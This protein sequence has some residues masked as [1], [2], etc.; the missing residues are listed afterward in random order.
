MSAPAIDKGYLLEALRR[1][2]EAPSPTG[3]TGAASAEIERMAGELGYKAGRRANGALVVTVP[4]PGD[5][6]AAVAA[7]FDTLGLMVRGINADGTLAFTSIGGNILPTLDGEYCR[8]HSASGRVYTGTVLSAAASLHVFPEAKT[9][10]R[11]EGNM[12]IRIDERV[13]SREEAAALGIE[14]GDFVSIEPKFCLTASGYVK[15]RHL[16]DKAGTACLLAALKLLAESGRV[17][18]RTV[19]FIFSAQEETGCG[20]SS[21]PEGV[22]TLIGVDMGCVGGELACTEHDVSL[23]VKDSSGPYDRALT[24]ELYALAQ[25]NGISC[26]KDV[27]PNYASDVSAARMGGN[28]IAG[29]L[30]GPGV[31]ASHGME[32]THTDALLGTARL[33]YIYITKNERGER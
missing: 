10:P 11:E 32:R 24:T 18:S 21:L 15:S 4:G 7:H 27:Y 30:I 20:C 33:V 9:A 19:K 25:A 12:L 2:V 26:R 13:R 3:F 5:G 29:A 16:D 23:C 6:C 14:T 17:P 8:V 22:D 31:S 28:D 1:L